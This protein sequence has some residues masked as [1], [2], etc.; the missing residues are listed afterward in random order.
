MGHFLGEVCI[1]TVIRIYK[2]IVSGGVIMEP[3]LSLF[4]DAIV[5][6]GLLAAGSFFAYLISVHFN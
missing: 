2:R 1:Y 3:Y 6:A 5:H 4:I